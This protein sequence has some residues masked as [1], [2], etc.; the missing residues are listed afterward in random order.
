MDFQSPPFVD[1]AQAGRKL[2]LAL[3]SLGL[4]NGVVYA[5]PRGGVPIGFEIAKA[6]HV[7]LDLCLVRKIPAPG[8]PELA[9]GAVVDGDRPQLVVNEIVQQLTGAS[10][11]YL[12]QEKAR[13]L[14]EIER[15]RRLYFGGRAQ[16]DPAGKT[17]IVVD[18]GLATGATARAAIKA[19]R[20]QGAGRVVLAVPVAPKDTAK[21]MRLEVDD[22]VCLLEPADFG[23]VG[24]YYA[25]FH[26]LS[27]DE[28]L[29]CLSRAETELP[30]S[31]FA[32]DL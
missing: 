10:A 19:L 31:P 3:A 5:L 25:D 2:A 11:A 1:R 8:Q 6:L 13:G 7:P 17:A 4:K 16:I 14:A 22:L 24:G 23:G 29:D 21:S 30:S 26:Q 28:V 12:E 15:R 20:R 32:K 27:D 9:L 18:D